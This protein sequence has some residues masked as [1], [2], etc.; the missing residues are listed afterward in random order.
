MTVGLSIPSSGDGPSVGL[1]GFLPRRGIFPVGTPGR[2][3]VELP[4]GLPPSA[5]RSLDH[6]LVEC[7][8]PHSLIRGASVRGLLHR[9]WNE[10][11]QDAYSVSWDPESE[12]LLVVVCDGVGSLPESR[13]AADFLTSIVPSLYFG[14]RSWNLTIQEA[15]QALL[16]Y[17]DQNSG[18]DSMA[19]TLVGVALAPA[20]CGLAADPGRLADS[21]YLRGSLVR[22]SHDLG[23]RTSGCAHSVADCTDPCGDVPDLHRD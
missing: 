2:A 17:A 13:R 6:A 10:E 23:T 1:D 4:D 18:V 20:S 22:Y 8:T 3:A 15:N 14:S 12:T 19:S 5:G 11:R 7:E 16:E 21:D 9:R